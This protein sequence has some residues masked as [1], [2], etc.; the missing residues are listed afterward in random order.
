MGF[1]Q[2]QDEVGADFWA[3]PLIPPAP[4]AAAQTIRV[5]RQS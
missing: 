1:P 5:K 4:A 2:E 3:Y